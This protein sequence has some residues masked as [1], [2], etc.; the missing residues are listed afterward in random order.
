MSMLAFALF[1]ISGV[2]SYVSEKLV[3][4]RLAS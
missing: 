4:I 2:T 3:G 1:D